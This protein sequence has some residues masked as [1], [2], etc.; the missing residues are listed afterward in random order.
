VHVKECWD[1]SPFKVGYLCTRFCI[2][3]A[4]PWRAPRQIAS[5]ILSMINCLQRLEYLVLP[6]P[7]VFMSEVPTQESENGNCTEDHD[8]LRRKVIRRI[9]QDKGKTHEI[10]C[11][12]AHREFKRRYIDLR[13]T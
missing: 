9:D 7:L 11:L 12:G 1:W 8:G 13:Q 6:Q 3:C 10:E 2:I 4:L 5:L